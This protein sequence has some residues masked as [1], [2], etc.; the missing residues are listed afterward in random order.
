MIKTYYFSRSRL[1]EVTHSDAV[2]LLDKLGY[3]DL[4]K[5]GL[6]GL[7]KQIIYFNKKQP[8]ELR[9]EKN[10]QVLDPLEVEFWN[11]L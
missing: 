1:R 6:I 2:I 4:A 10:Y 7:E 9:P 3:S 8:S 11:I 5:K